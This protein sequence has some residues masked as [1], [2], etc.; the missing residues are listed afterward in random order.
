VV[1]Q[2][3]KNLTEGHRTTAEQYNVPSKSLDAGQLDKLRGDL[4]AAQK[5]LR[6]HYDAIQT[7]I[8]ESFQRQTQ[9]FR[10]T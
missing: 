3:L 8:E 2:V 5:T 1:K 6:A 4:N 7:S 9:L 10:R